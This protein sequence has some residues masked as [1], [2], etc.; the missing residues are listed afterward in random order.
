[1][2]HR[3]TNNCSNEQPRVAILLSTYNGEKF[4]VEQLESLLGQSYENFILVI[5]DDGSTDNTLQ[6]LEANAEKHPSKLALLPADN[7][8]LGARGSFSKLIEYVLENKNI[9]GMNKAYMMLCDQD[10]TWFE[11]KVNTQVAEIIK[12]EA[13]HPG[14][15]VLVHTDL[16]VVSEDNTPIAESLIKFQG[17][18]IERNR[19]P[20]LVISNLVT[21]C[22]ALMNEEL[23]QISMPVSHEAIMHDWWLALVA[24]AFGKLI[25]LNQ[26]LVHYSQHGNNTI[27]AKEYV[28]TNPLRRSF[29]DRLFGTRPNEHLYEVAIQATA[30]RK[31]FADKLSIKDRIKLRISA[32]MGIRVGFLQRLF[33][34]LARRL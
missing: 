4:V 34:R 30:F 22:T 29:Y 21:G 28:G 16:E 25:F 2:T 7:K 26:P 13:E 8:N 24:S 17:L 32:C 11:E 10:D 19:F 18:E 23:A 5:R 3:Q 12:I 31:R 14:I 33:Y 27:G 6:L 1:V 9:L 15:P 20:H